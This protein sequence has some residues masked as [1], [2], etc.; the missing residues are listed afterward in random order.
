MRENHHNLREGRRGRAGSSGLRMRRPYPFRVV[1]LGE[2]DAKLNWEWASIASDEVT[3]GQ[4]H[5]TQAPSC[6]M[7]CLPNLRP[8]GS[9]HL[10]TQLL[11][12]SDLEGNG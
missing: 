4:V 1:E 2:N 12:G 11:R 8:E 3:C 6:T 5:L 10:G 9:W 7:Y